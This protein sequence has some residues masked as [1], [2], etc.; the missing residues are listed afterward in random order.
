MS[1]NS[2]PEALLLK[3][4]VIREDRQDPLP[5]HGLY[6]NAI[7]QAVT[8]VESSGIKLEL[9]QECLVALRDNSHTGSAM[10]A[11]TVS[12]PRLLS[13]VSPAKKVSTSRSTSSEIETWPPARS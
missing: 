12:T 10:M 4:P 2:C 13:Q 1:R 5:A 11:R 7:D 9:R 3:V 8:L 6:R